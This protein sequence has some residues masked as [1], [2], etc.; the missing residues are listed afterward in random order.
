MYTP[1]QL[2]SPDYFLPAVGP[3]QYADYAPPG[4]EAACPGLAAEGGIPPSR[5]GRLAGKP[6]SGN[7]LD[8]NGASSGMACLAGCAAGAG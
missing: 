7:T 6:P 2:P 8:G 3:H 4:Y 1:T 5:A